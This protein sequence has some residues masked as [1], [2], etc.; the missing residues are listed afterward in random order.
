MTSISS[1]SIGFVWGWLFLL[2]KF[3]ALRWRRLWGLLTFALATVLLSF[4]LYFYFN[5]VAVV[6]FFL[7]MAF[8]FIL[9]V[10]WRKSIRD[11]NKTLRNYPIT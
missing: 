5:L 7:A 8:S 11:K 9:H 6:I 2:Y 4:Q 3:P 1:I 10:S